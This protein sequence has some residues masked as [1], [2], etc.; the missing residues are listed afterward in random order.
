MQLEDP[1]LTE[2]YHQLVV[3]SSFDSAEQILE[4]AAKRQFFDEHISDTKYKHKWR[5]INPE[6]SKIVVNYKI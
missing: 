1:I 4:M 6:K 5:K 3:V 2:L